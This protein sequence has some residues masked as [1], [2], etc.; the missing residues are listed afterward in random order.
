MA[1][2][3]IVYY[4]PANARRA[5]IYS[6]ATVPGGSARSQAPVPG[7]PAAGRLLLARP[8]WPAQAPGWPARTVPGARRNGPAAKCPAKP[9]P[10]GANYIAELLARWLL[11][12]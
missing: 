4:C 2:G 3:E 7:G 6:G 5:R 1:P 8:N 11:L 12:I 9:G 10:A